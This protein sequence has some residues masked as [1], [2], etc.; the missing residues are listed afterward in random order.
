M[1]KSYYLL[2]TVFLGMSLTLTGCKKKSRTV[3]DESTVSAKD[4]TR[5]LWGNGEDDKFSGPQSEDFVAL[6]DEDLKAQF[7][8][9]AIP[10]SALTP[11][12]Y[13]SGLP[14]HDRF[15]VPTDML[16]GI[17]HNVHFNTDEY[18]LKNQ[19]DLAAIENIAHYLRE[20][21]GTFVYIE[22]C[23][24]QR[25]PEAYNFSLGAR[26]ANYVRSQLVK[27]GVN[28]DQLFTISFG[29]EKLLDPRNTPDAWAK[30]RRAEFKIFQK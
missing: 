15:H 4:S 20:N 7:S 3:W 13:G 2:A 29:K 6:K 10:Q 23:C 22:G 30:N 24:D 28:P 25:G 8:D 5:S 16:A 26:R 27:K 18:E 1:K 9:N 19:D 21:K 12:E 11:G 14:S 17:F